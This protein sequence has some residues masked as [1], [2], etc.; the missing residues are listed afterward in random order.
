MVEMRH[1]RMTLDRFLVQRQRAHPGAGGEMTRVMGQFGTVG[2]IISSDM[3][4]A[5]LERLT[6]LTGDINVQG[7][8]VRK[9]DEVGNAIFVEAFEYVDLVGA[10]VSE[11]MAEPLV[12]ASGGTP[13]KYV[14]L[15]DP[16][17]GSS[18]L[19]VDCVVGSIFS[20]RNLKGTVEESIL[21]KGGAQIAAGYLMY[22]TSTV[23][24]YTA[25][26]GVHTFVLDEEIG[27]FV[28]DHENV[29]MPE[30]GSTMA[31]NFG[32]YG[33]WGE[34]TRRFV[35]SLGTEGKDRYSL[36]YSGALVA[37]LHQILHRGGIYFY[38]ED[39]NKPKGK[40]RLLYECA[41]LSMIAEQAGGGATTGKE[42]VSDIQPQ[43]VHQRIPFAI[44]SRYEIEKYEEAYR[45]TEGS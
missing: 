8:K 32:N 20:I 33:I 12:I 19:D 45:G 43:S 7:E 4:R 13:G 40:L 24:V 36:R 15:V 35:D 37:D 21:Q 9:L 2:K 39:T 1:G 18:N 41:P 38:P 42:K 26:D 6:G 29:R 25:G 31:S 11:E 5:A 17:D 30:R 3:R 10:I 28:L 16:I 44:G 14:V 27:E 22:G 34:P 23:L